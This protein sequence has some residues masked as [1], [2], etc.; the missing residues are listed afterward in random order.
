MKGCFFYLMAFGFA[1][2]AMSAFSQENNS[3]EVKIIEPS[4][5]SKYDLNSQI[6]YRIK[7][8]DKEDGESAYGEIATNEVFLEVRYLPDPSIA[9]SVA[10]VDPPGLAAMKKSNCFNCHA[11]N[12][13]LIAPSFYEI[14]KRYPPTTANTDLLAKRIREGSGGIWG[15]ASMPSHAELTTQ[16]V[17]EI[18]AWI[19]E[20]GNDQNLN[21]YTGTE[22]VI[23]LKMPGKVGQKG[24]FILSATYSDHG[25]K[26][27]SQQ[28][29]T[30]KDVVVVY[31]K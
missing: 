15:T 24:A 27:N 10:K 30:S 21:Y 8:S 22:G 18:V 23:K 14:A 9:S 7:I 2:V 1:S 13:K 6:P 31:I 25:A 20:N 3:P 28:S 12:G 19:S 16:Q 5:K 26:N 11:F 17:Q 4:P 29:L